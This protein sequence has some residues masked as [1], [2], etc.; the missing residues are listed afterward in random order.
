M[1]RITHKATVDGKEYTV[2][3]LWE[4]RISFTDYN[5]DNDDE[6]VDFSFDTYDEANEC[7]LSYNEAEYDVASI[8]EIQMVRGEFGVPIDW[9]VQKK[10]FKKT[11]HKYIEI[12]N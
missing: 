12:Y 9:G 6:E 11:R 2:E 5:E 3:H 10:L 4:L 7:L 1:P 8:S